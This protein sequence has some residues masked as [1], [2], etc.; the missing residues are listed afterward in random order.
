MNNYILKPDFEPQNRYENA[1][2]AL[3]EAGKATLPVSAD[4]TFTDASNL[5]ID[6]VTY[7]LDQFMDPASGIDFFYVGTNT[8][9]VIQGGEVI[10]MNR[11][12]IP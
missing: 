11:I 10:A 5:E 7:T 6:P 1:L 2:K 9:I 12:Y 4:F 8:E 3:L